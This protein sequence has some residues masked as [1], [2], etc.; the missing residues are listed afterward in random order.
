MASTEQDQRKDGAAEGRDEAREF[1]E[2]TWG[3]GSAS[4]L[5]SL[6]QREARRSRSV[7]R[8]E[9]SDRPSAD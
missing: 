2:S 7:P 9:S 1:Q 4:A 8:Q 3:E 6:K 5:E